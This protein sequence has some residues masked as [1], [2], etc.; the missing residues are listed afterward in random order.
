MIFV[1]IFRTRLKDIHR[2]RLS[3][4]IDR[5]R[6]GNNEWSRHSRLVFELKKENTPDIHIVKL[7]K[8]SGPVSPVRP[9]TVPNKLRKRLTLADK[10]R[11]SKT[12]TNGFCKKYSPLKAISYPNP[13]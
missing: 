7:N 2:G 3:R 6:N 10:D 11:F 4:K 8:P 5:A 13:R 1:N 9:K 12:A